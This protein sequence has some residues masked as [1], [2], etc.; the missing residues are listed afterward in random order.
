MDNEN[1]AQIDSLDCYNPNYPI[2]HY[3][4]TSGIADLAI[5]GQNCPSFACTVIEVYEIKGD[6]IT[7]NLLWS[8]NGNTNGWIVGDYLFSATVDSP[9]GFIGYPVNAYNLYNADIEWQLPNGA[10]YIDGFFGGLVDYGHQ[11]TKFT[12]F[13]IDNNKLYA[14]S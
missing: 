8:N 2:F 14:Y 5:I 4:K 11:N 6:N 10:G 13:V 9:Q 3:N 1:G 12:V 7:S